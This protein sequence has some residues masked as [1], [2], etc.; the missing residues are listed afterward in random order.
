MRSVLPV[1][2]YFVSV[3][4]SYAAPMARYGVDA[5]E[6]GTLAQRAPATAQRI[7]RGEALLR[8]ATTVADFEKA[9]ALFR[10]AA[11]EAP[12]S[13]LVWRR[14]CQALTLLGRH[15]E[16]VR[17]CAKALYEHNTSGLALRA[18]VGALMSGPESPTGTETGY[19]IVHAS[20][21]RQVLS[22]DPAGYAGQCDIAEKLGDI[23]MLKACIFELQR[24]A[25]G[26]YETER[27]I[28]FEASIRPGWRT[29]AGWVAL[30]LLASATLLHALIRRRAAAIVGAGAII[31]ASMGFSKSVRA[32]EPATARAAEGRPVLA[33]HLS[34]YAVN[35]D[36]PE[37]SLPTE[38]QRD[39][40][41]VEFGY[42]IMDL[43]DHAEW[44]IKKGDNKKAA[45]YYLALGK[46]VPD[47]AVGFVKACEQLELAGEMDAATEACASALSL[48]GV[49]L[50][51]YSH[52]ARLALRK[53]SLTPADIGN[54]DSVVKHLEEDPS[55]RAVGLDIQC[56]LGSHESDLV[57]LR[58]CVPLLVA[59]APDSPKTLFYEWALAVKTGDFASA[60]RL[61]SRARAK[62]PK[63]EQLAQMESATFD[64]M[65]A[66]RKGLRAFR[67]WRVGALV[68]VVLAM[69]LAAL[70][71]RRRTVS[72]RANA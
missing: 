63:N 5:V 60:E 67:D 43:G 58:H 35:D 38:E 14:S 40:D 25:P 52:Y 13:A 21:A 56:T 17:A 69:G 7:E 41:P 30:G 11:R 36:N 10:E 9:A 15:D 71:M 39:A 62:S 48:K 57:R 37:A 33:G 24:V 22:N 26:H 50:A 59:L 6:L 65:P 16:A 27:A 1:I 32:D 31:A 12:H 4:S 8:A 19:A 34:K 23:E 66:W 47:T 18:T 29:V 28:A 55:T 72:T 61:L 68:S 49:T 45:R 70:L 54:L 42:F 46:L 20:R 64:A 44:A 3:T 53:K 51:D 2:A